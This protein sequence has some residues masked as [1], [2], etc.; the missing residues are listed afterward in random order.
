MKSCAKNHAS[1]QWHN[2]QLECPV[3][4]VM[5]DLVRVVA[6]LESL[7]LQT[8]A[9]KDTETRKGFSHAS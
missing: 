9:D 5:E 7:K 1:I 8:M 6:E 2:P 3:C 4:D